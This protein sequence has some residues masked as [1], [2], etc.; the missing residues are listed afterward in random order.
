MVSTSAVLVSVTVTEMVCTVLGDE[1]P[2]ALVMVTKTLAPSR[3]EGTV[4]P[5]EVVKCK[6]T[7]APF[8][9]GGTN[10]AE[11]VIA[12]PPMVT[13]LLTMPVALTL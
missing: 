5:P 2:T 1:L 13:L 10:V 7:D 8:V 12:V 11:E 9:G 4:T 3:Y 6:L